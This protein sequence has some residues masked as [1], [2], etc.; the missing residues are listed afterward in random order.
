MLLSSLIYFAR[1]NTEK[2]QVTRFTCQSQHGTRHA[3]GFLC[4]GSMLLNNNCTFSSM[5]IDL[6]CFFGVMQT[7]IMWLIG[8]FSGSSHHPALMFWMDYAHNGMVF[9][10]VLNLVAKSKNCPRRAVF[11]ARWL[12]G[13]Q[14]Y[15]IRFFNVPRFVWICGIFTNFQRE[16][17]FFFVGKMEDKEPP[18][19]RDFAFGNFLFH[20]GHRVFLLTNRNPSISTW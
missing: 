1:K 12:K 4:C 14:R 9:F 10:Q 2:H 8:W 6:R 3:A 7:C 11:S 18:L 19:P 17:F 13:I 5:A 20:P 16:T 15:I